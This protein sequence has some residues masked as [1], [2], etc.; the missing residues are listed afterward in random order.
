MAKVEYRIVVLEDGKEVLSESLSCELIHTIATFYPDKPSSKLFFKYAAMHPSAQVREQIAY[1]NQLDEE[2]CR[3]LAEDN[4]VSVLK[5]LLQNNPFKE[6]ATFENIERIIKKDAELA[7]SVAQELELFKSIDIFK[8][9]ELVASQNDP[10]VALALA[11]NKRTPKKILRDLS[12]HDDPLISDLA[13]E[14]L[15]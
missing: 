8:L 6:I 5:Y 10:T 15:K 12:M 9:A 3:T 7:T 2:S 11:Q 14:N 4:S 13:R 1:K